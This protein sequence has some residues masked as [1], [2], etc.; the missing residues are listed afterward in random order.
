M[1]NRR[2]GFAHSDH[3]DTAKG[4]AHVVFDERTLRQLIADLRP[5]AIDYWQ[6]KNETIFDRVSVVKPEGR[7]YARLL[8]VKG[9]DGSLAVRDVFG[10]QFRLNHASTPFLAVAAR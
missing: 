5:F 1:K 2:K 7:S 4:Q 3:D 10:Y 6:C 8:F 9:L